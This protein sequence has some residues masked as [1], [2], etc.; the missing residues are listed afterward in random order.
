[1]GRPK[2]SSSWPPKYRKHASGQARVTLPGVGDVYLGKFNSPESWE[3][4]ARVIA[5]AKLRGMVDPRTS[6]ATITIGEVCAAFWLSAVER[7][8]PSADVRR[9]RL[10]R[11]RSVIRILRDHYGDALAGDFTAAKLEGLMDHLVTLPYTGGRKMKGSTC[12]TR[13]GINM[14]SADVKTIFAWAVKRD[15]VGGSVYHGLTA[16][17]RLRAGDTDAREPDP[18]QPVDDATVEATL[19]V[20]AKPSADLIRLIRLTG[21]RVGEAVQIRAADLKMEGPVWEFRPPKHKTRRRG[22]ERVVPIGPK[23]QEIIRR[24]LKASPAAFLFTPR[25][26]LAAM[27]AK[28]RAEA[29]A[30]GIRT[31][32]QLDKANASRRH[33][34]RKVSPVQYTVNTVEKAIQQAADR[35]DRDAHRKQPGVPVGERLVPRWHPHQLRHAFATELAESTDNIRVVM[36][37]LGHTTERMTHRYVKR[38]PADITDAIGRIG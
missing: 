11:F 5:K 2:G 1:M 29:L 12:R 13:A 34:H 32:A 26:S 36:R 17:K 8:F 35:A 15:L 27:R 21:M 9:N 31:A 33:G 25:D 30:R 4:Y 23:G 3:E 19:A 20:M 10:S 7:P 37:A 6:T 18:V 14:F 38:Q 16:V 24:N 22:I 28:Q